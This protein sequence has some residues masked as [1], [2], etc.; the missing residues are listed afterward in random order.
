MLNG[1]HNI[2]SYVHGVIKLWKDHKVVILWHVYVAKV[3]AICAVNLGNQIIKIILNAI[4][5]KNVMMI[6]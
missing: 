2:L 6:K 1:L 3:F 4:Y 5:I